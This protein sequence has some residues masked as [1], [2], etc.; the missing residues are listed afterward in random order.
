MSL[1]GLQSNKVTTLCIRPNDDHTTFSEMLDFEFA[2]QTGIIN[3]Q[4]DYRKKS[5]GDIQ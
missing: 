5:T 3:G 1:N 4:S 2:K